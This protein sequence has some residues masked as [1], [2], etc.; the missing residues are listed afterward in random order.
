MPRG[1]L[2]LQLIKPLIG[3]DM[4]G[5]WPDSF[6]W[7]SWARAVCVT[8]CIYP[9]RRIQPLQIVGCS[10][11]NLH[12]C[13]RSCSSLALFFKLGCWVETDWQSV[14]T[15]YVNSTFPCQLW[16]HHR[17]CATLDVTQVACC[18]EVNQG[19]TSAP[20]SAYGPLSKKPPHIKIFDGSANLSSYRKTR[21]G[22]E[23]IKDGKCSSE[24][25][26][27]HEQAG[28]SHRVLCVVLSTS[29]SPAVGREGGVYEVCS[30]CLSDYQ[31]GDSHEL[32]NSGFLLAWTFSLEALLCRPKTASLRFLGKALPLGKAGCTSFVLPTQ[33]VSRCGYS[34]VSTALSN[35]A[36]EELCCFFLAFWQ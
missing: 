20:Y 17:V 1:L 18:S 11:L 21:R 6:L 22:L 16:S 8:E 10:L 4:P 19:D 29:S 23:H 27:C 28:E 3:Y 2:P 13:V 32:R 9:L 7:C 14:A 24:Q 35:M 30:L 15:S 5:I 25:R 12:F 33:P 31:L 26:K 34:C 36:R